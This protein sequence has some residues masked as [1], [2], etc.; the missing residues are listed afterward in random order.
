[1]HKTPK[2]QDL[3]ASKLRAHP[4]LL[5][6]LNY[7]LLSYTLQPLL[8]G[9]IFQVSQ[10]ILSSKKVHSSEHIYSFQLH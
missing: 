1:M 6:M 4:K 9:I 2:Q 8:Q 3:A 10:Y 5:A 7:S